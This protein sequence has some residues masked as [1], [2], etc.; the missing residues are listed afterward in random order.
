MP[1]RGCS[2]ASPGAPQDVKDPTIDVKDK[3]T[4]MEET[5]RS[6]NTLGVG[7]ARELAAVARKAAKTMTAK[8]S[9]DK[10]TAET[11]RPMEATATH[12]TAP[13]D[14]KQAKK[15]AATETM[16]AIGVPVKA[17]KA[18]MGDINKATN[19]TINAET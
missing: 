2:Q 5:S 3:T 4:K 10:D 17:M 16:K 15:A 18:T 7:E 8:T 13:S 6:G 19:N 9:E 1:C 12:T 14:T 11:V